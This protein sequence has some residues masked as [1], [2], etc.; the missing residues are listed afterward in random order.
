[1]SDFKNI[2][3]GANFAIYNNKYDKELI[4]LCFDNP[5][6]LFKTGTILKDS[7]TTKAAI[8]KVQNTD[9]F[10]KRYNNKGLKFTLRYIFRKARSFRA[11][12]AAIILTKLNIPTPLPIIAMQKKNLFILEA[13]YLFTETLTNLVSLEKFLDIA[14]KDE[15][16]FANFAN[17]IMNYLKILHNNGIEHRDFKMNN[18]YIQDQANNKFSFGLWDLDSLKMRK[19]E[20]SK[21]KREKDISRLAKSLT[22]ICKEFNIPT[23][24]NFKNELITI[25]ENK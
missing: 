7:R 2:K 19:K 23:N 25:Y 20:V 24:K 6:Q 9:I 8:I 16:I 5:D 11:W 14:I 12:K 1:M 4:S 18:I 13:G 10:L 22:E 3:E 17:V 15:T 21:E